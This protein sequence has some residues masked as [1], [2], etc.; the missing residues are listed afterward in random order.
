MRALCWWFRL[1][2][3]LHVHH[4]TYAG[5][6]A[7]SGGADGWIYRIEWKG[8][9][10]AHIG[11][12]KVDN[13]LFPSWPSKNLIY[14]RSEKK[15]LPHTLEWRCS[16]VPR[17][18]SLAFQIHSQ[19]RAYKWPTGSPPSKLQFSLRLRWWASSGSGMGA[20]P[21]SCLVDCCRCRNRWVLWRWKYTKTIENR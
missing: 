1:M 6:Y 8:C 4:W 18:L 14:K 9:V 21:R 17:A 13:A 2:L 16:I 19:I 7:Y 5:V 12:G 10:L 20:A 3:L 15:E 11:R